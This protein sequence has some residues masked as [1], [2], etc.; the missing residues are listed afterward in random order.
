MY[1][2]SVRVEDFG[3]IGHLEVDLDEGLNVISGP[4]EAGKSTLMQAIWFALTRRSTS[5]ASEIRTIEPKSGGTPAVEVCLHVDGTQYTLEKVFNGQSGRTHLK[6][7]PSDGAMKEQN[8]EEADEVIREAVGF[9]DAS[10]RTGVPEHFGFWPAV[11]VGQDDR[12]TDPGKHLTDEGDPESISTVLAQI[13]GDV[14]AGSGGEIVDRAREEYERFFT[15]SGNYTT[16]SG[17]P[18]HQARQ[19]LE[20]TEERFEELKGKRDSYEED[21]DELERLRGRIEGIDEQLPELEEE[22]EKA[23][24]EFER[25]EELRGEQETARSKLETAKSEAG[26]IEDRLGRRTELQEKVQDQKAELEEKQEEAE[27]KEEVLE[28]HRGER[29][30]LKSRVEEARREKEALDRRL[31]EL[32]AHLDVLRVE[33]RLEA[34][35][36]Q[37]G[38][39]QE[40]KERRD[41][42]TGNAEG[43]AADEES[44]KDLEE[45]KETHNQARTRL[46]TAAAQLR[47]RATG[48]TDIRVGDEKLSL[49]EGEEE[50]RLIDEPTTVGVASLLEID[51]EP[52]GEDLI[53]IR[54][55]ARQAKEDYETAL[56][57]LGADSVAEARGDLQRKRELENELE[58]VKGQIEELMPE[59]GSDL[60]EA[61]ARLESRLETAKEKRDSYSEDEL[62][63]EEEPLPKEEEEVQDLLG[64]AEEDLETAEE[65]LGE[66]REALSEH[67]E[68]A[69]ELREDLQTAET[70]VESTE[71]SL[72]AARNDLEAH[73][74]E[75]GPE[76]QLQ[77][78]L[79][80]AESDVDEKEGEVEELEDELEDLSPEDVE[81]KKERAEDSFQNTKKERR[82]LKSE[83]DKIQGRLE[84]D[85]LRGLHS[86]LQKARQNRNEARAEVERL[87]K[88]AEAAKLLYNTLTEKRAEARRQYLAPLR[89]EV[90]DLLNRFFGADSASVEFAEDFGL[91]TLSRSNKGGFD[92]GQLSAGATQQLS[93][94]IRLAMARLIAEERPHPVFLDDALSDTD[95]D[96]FAAIANILRSVAREMQIIMTTC[97]HERHRRLGVSTKRMDS[98]K[99]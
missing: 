35:E 22:A 41:E 80:K 75:H 25:A 63:S 92:F 85:A 81:A 9:G 74:E 49:S 65:E 87:E 57:E 15:G 71:E 61:R 95:P 21:L 77:S 51:I 84:D 5:Q 62:D 82:D 30:E 93:V 78:D 88:Q 64:E 50:E 24:E 99:R 29:D 91:Q 32:R 59:E 54:E 53:T 19:E 94:L 90:E 36:A 18:L 11:W 10:G 60:E 8:G 40:L 46:E 17:A 14:L 28:D 44:I 43:I 45:L 26:R 52:G 97:H 20:R 56:E 3:P 79:E 89:E 6:V 55:Q 23:R 70:K 12:R 48:D 27:K 33:E 2:E 34:I 83:L 39:L 58:S 4:N 86:R 69:Q 67:D 72:S 1:F 42:L 98:L 73:E 37:A 68:K 76:E 16:R 66:A 96:R 31:R 7:D 38:E 13:G 47:F